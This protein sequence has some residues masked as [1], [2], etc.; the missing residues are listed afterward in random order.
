MV[1]TY[2]DLGHAEPV[3]TSEPPPQTTYYLPMHAVMKDSSTTTK[4]RVVFD[5]SAITSSGTSL[6]QSLL[7]GPTLQPTLNNILLK[8]RCYPIAL[9]A[10]IS[11][12][13]REVLLHPSDKDL[14]RFVWGASP[15]DPLQDYRMCRVTFE[16]SASPYLAVKTLQQTAKEHGEDYPDVTNHILSSF[17]VDDFLGG[18]D[19]A[20][21]ALDLYTHMCEVLQKGGFNLTKWRSSS[22][23]VLQ[24]IPVHLQ[25]STPIKDSTSEQAPT[26]SKALGLV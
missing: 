7:V 15:T 20:Q 16:V 5:G 14:H 3:P 17:Y 6:N 18:D 23:E 1:Q 19:S 9:N 22:K 10:D 21:E 26:I 12:M 24:G 13:Y 11:K 8:F 2:L 4:L 25:E